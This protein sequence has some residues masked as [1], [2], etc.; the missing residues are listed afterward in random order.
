MAAHFQ[1]RESGSADK[2]AVLHPDLVGI[3]KVSFI[4]TG[5]HFSQSFNTEGKQVLHSS[6]IIFQ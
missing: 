1:F 4:K 2:K 5:L 3:K 6:K